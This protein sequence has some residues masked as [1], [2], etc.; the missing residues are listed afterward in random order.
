[1]CV[2]VCI[3]LHHCAVY[4]VRPRFA[5]GTRDGALNAASSLCSRHHCTLLLLCITSFIT[6]HVALGAENSVVLPRCSQN[7]RGITVV[8][9]EPAWYYRGA[10]RTSVVLTWCSQNQRGVTV[11]LPWCS[12]N[13]VV[14]LW[15]TQNQHDVTVVLSDPAWHYRG[16]LRG[17]QPA[18]CSPISYQ[19][20]L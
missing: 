19:K 2:R 14:F 20:W 3:V 6:L 1:M 8:L 15:C 4:T 11:V 5:R 12:Q 7:Q 10:L 17:W 13:T 16:A 9:S 18:N